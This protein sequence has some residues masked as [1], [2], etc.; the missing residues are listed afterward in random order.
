MGRVEGHPRR[1]ARSTTGVEFELLLAEGV[2]ARTV[3][4]LAEPR[5]E[6]GIGLLI[7][8]CSSVHTIGMR[9]AIDVAFVRWPPPDDGPVEILSVAAD[10][11]PCRMAR[12]ARGLHR[13]EVA[14]LELAAGEAARLG[15]AAGG[16]IALGPPVG[17]TRP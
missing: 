15:L 6:R 4:L 9:F 17:A 8:R 14:A 16:E 2:S 13:R 5:L 11:R 7:S 1:R 10:V 3:G 12:A